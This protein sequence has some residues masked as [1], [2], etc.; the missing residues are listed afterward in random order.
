MVT[1]NEQLAELLNQDQTSATNFDGAFHQALE[2]VG[3]RH[4]IYEAMTQT[5]PVTPQELAG[6]TNLCLSHVQLWLE[7]MASLG[8]C[9]YSAP[10]NRYC[11]WCIWPAKPANVSN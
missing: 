4:G 2:A 9:Y 7:A 1:I 8:Y 11:L 6:F 10:A 3:E 5:G